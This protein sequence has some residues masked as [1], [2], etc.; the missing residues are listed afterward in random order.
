MSTTDSAGG[1]LIPA[2]LDPAI[3]LSSAGS[4][5]PIREMARVVQTVGDVYHAVSSDGVVAHWYA[6]AAEVTDDSP[7]LA[8]PTIPSHR[9]SCWVPWSVEVEGDAVGFVTEIGRLLVD[10]ITQLW[11][12]AYTVGTG[13]GQPTG[14]ITALTGTA[15]EINT[16]GTEALIASDPYTLQAALPP[17]FQANSAWAAN[18]PII[19]QLR[20]FETTNGALKWPSLQDEPPMLLGRRMFEVSNMDGAINAAATANNFVLVVGDWSQFVITDRVGT[21]IELVP[22]VFGSNRRP[23]GQRGFYAWFRTGS[24]VLVDNAFRMLDV[25]T[26]A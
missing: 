2:Q 18:L 12:E 19:N 4:S 25:P 9:G 3:L 26:T 1:Y 14:F 17:R 24:D 21:S 10:G 15:S 11:A 20:Q 13:S 6:E 7:T 22:H 5:N 16:G 8:Q 23:T